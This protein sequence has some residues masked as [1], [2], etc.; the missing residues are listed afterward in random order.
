MSSQLIPITFHKVLQ[1]QSYTVVVLG[2]PEK[3]FSIYMQPQVGK[4]I[5]NYLAQ[6]KKERP[7]SH[8]LIQSILKGYDIRPKQ[9]VIDDVQDSVYFA[10]LFL[11]TTFEEKK[12]I[13]EIDARP[14]D[15]ITLALLSNIPM[16]CQK[17]V[18]DKVTSYQ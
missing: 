11:E 7:S 2:T 15:C 6:G 9:I 16:F 3:Q 10:K 12:T 13:L 4:D 1:S 8:N 5:Q 14:S 17:Q 18:M